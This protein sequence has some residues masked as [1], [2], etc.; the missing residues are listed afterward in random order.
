MSLENRT[1]AIFFLEFLAL[2]IKKP[3]VSAEG[4]QTCSCARLPFCHPS[5]FKWAS[6]TRKSCLFFLLLFLA[7]LLLSGAAGCCPC[8]GLLQSCR[9]KQG[10]SARA[11]QYM[12]TLHTRGGL[13]WEPFGK[14]CWA[15]VYGSRQHAGLMFYRSFMHTWETFKVPHQLCSRHSRSIKLCIEYTGTLYMSI[16]H[17]MGSFRKGT[18]IHIF[19]CAARIFMASIYCWDLLIYMYHYMG[20]FNWGPYIYIYMEGLCTQ[21]RMPNA[22]PVVLMC[23]TCIAGPLSVYIGLIYMALLLWGIS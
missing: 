8:S 20:S 10:F 1:I 19:S 11:D 21:F 15:G 6:K 5:L 22:E 4:T 14:L 17:Y 9:G 23:I 18:L 12:Y 13:R 2:L 7:C 3:Q 16:H